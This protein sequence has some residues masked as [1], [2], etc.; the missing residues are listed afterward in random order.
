MI[1]WIMYGKIKEHKRNGLNRNQIKRR[2]NID[3][4]TVYKYWDMTPDEYASIN[5]KSKS[6][7]K[8]ADK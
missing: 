6:R 4:K 8:K 1:T 5:E 7:K 3:Y 2:L